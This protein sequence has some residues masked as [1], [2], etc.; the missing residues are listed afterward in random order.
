MN[1]LITGSIGFIGFHLSKKL[2][3][4][5]FFVVG[6][7]NQNNY[8]DVDLKLQRLSILNKYKLYKHHNIDISNK[9]DLNKLFDTNHFDIIVNL[10]AQAGVRFSIDHPEEYINSNINGFFNVLENVKKTK[11]K[12]IY[13]SSSSVYG[14]A[15]NFPSSEN[16]NTDNPVSL[17][18][19]SKKCN[20]VIAK[21]YSNL[22]GLQIVGLRFFTVYGPW[23]RPDM[24]LF[25]FTKAILN[26]E[27]I[28]VHNYGKHSRDFTYIDDITEAIYLLMRYKKFNS[29]DGIYNIGS[30][31]PIQLLKFIEE[32]ENKLQKKAIIRFQDKQPGDVLKTFSNTKRLFNTLDFKPNVSLEKGISEFIDWYVDFYE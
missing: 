14:D 23:G 11:S 2:L 24:A 25:K 18:A 10:A 6:V 20:E 15:K 8:Y 4:N 19:A 27:P 17:Y 28:N 21:S 3:E 29:L 1:V 26:N 31:N 5:D 30:G 7:D 22:Y 13:A 32:I 12:L 9:K 16:D